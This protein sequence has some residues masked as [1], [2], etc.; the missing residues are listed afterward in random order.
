MR[1]INTL[2]LHEDLNE[3]I[4]RHCEKMNDYRDEL[5]E[6]ELEVLYE[7]MTCLMEICEDL[8]NYAIERR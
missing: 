3:F 5:D 2:T 8:Y 6:E 4:S 1:K 7:A